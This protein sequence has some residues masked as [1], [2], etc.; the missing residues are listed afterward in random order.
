M[1][2]TADRFVP[3]QPIRLV[4]ADSG[5]QRRGARVL[6]RVGELVEQRPAFVAAPLQLGGRSR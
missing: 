6:Y 5:S 2:T 3:N 1:I 4:P